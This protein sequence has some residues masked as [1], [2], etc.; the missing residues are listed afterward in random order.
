MVAKYPE[1]EERFFDEEAERQMAFLME[2]VRRIRALRADLGIPTAKV[3][4][5]VACDD[6]QV[7]H[8][9]SD[10]LWWLQFVGRINEVRFVKEGETVPQA[11]S[12][13]VDGA[14]IFVPLGGIVDIGK[15]KERWQK[16]LSEL[17]REMERVQARLTN[18]QFIERAP[19]EVVAAERQRF[20]ELQQQRE[21]L[22]RRLRS[23]GGNP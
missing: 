19:A 23:L 13:L 9:I 11:V 7:P 22:E 1:A 14:E 20:A 3:D 21:A 18:P 17:A 16:R 8:L 5:V 10:N 12:E 15:L 4:I 2:T 6:K